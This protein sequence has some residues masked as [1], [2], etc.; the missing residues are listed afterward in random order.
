MQIT[1]E[2]AVEGLIAYIGDLVSQLK[3]P[4]ESLFGNAILAAMR[5]N[6]SGL[7]AKARPWL[8]MSGL[9]QNNMVQL[10]PLKAA[11]DA[12]FVKVPTITYMGWTFTADDVQAL[13]AKM[14]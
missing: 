8:E 13:M 6:H 2:R 7:D 5:N 3:N 10:E 4:I 14:R 1:L 11:L 12:A 9:M